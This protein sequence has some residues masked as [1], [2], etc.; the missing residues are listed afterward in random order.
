MSSPAS[1]HSQSHSRVEAHSSLIDAPVRIAAISLV[2][3]A[4]LLALKLVLGLLSGSIAVLSDAVDSGTDLVGGLA[5]LLSVQFARQPADEQHPYGHGKIEA[6]SASVAATIIGLGGGLI[7]FQA[8]RRLIEGSP[9]I[10]VGVGLMAMVIAATANVVVS[11]FMSREAKRHG[12]MALAA[13]STHLR[14]N[15]VQAGAIIAGLLLVLATGEAVFDPITALVLAAY[16]AW[17]AFGLVRVAV[18]EILDRALPAAEIEAIVDV[19]RRHSGEIRGYHRLRTR[20]SGSTREIDMH[21]LFDASR[22]VTQVHETSDRIADDIHARLHGSI[23]VIHVEPDD[24]SDSS[25][26]EGWIIP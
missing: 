12:S 22:T 26:E 8:V 1:P 14:T 7:T 3:T 16:M 20:R 19:L 6:V 21:L 13:E 15:V 24:G 23:V 18:N 17:T 10:D 5:A 9:D 2:V 4:F 25:P 11:V